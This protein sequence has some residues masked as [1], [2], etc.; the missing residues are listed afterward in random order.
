MKKL[1]AIIMSA[2]IVLSTASCGGKGGSQV[3]V[4]IPRLMP[5]NIMPVETVVQFTGGTMRASDDGLVAEGN[6]TM[7][8]YVTEPI[9]AADSVSVMIEQ[10]S[11]TLTASQVW[12]DYENNR[13][14][15]SDAEAV[16]G[17]GTDCYIAYPYINVYHKG[18]YLRIGAGSGSDEYQ[19]QLLVNLASNAV[20]V[21]DQ[22]IPAGA[23]NAAQDNIIK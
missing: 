1:F 8:T 15:R 18:C 10:F 6:G 3:N 20:A 23:E 11:D 5:E 14:K 21:L 4:Q 19:K 2:A 9:G 7:V 17:I 22:Y 13:I 16:S 12:S